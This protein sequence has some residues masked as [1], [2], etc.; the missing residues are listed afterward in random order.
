MRVSHDAVTT[1][2]S[3]H[4]FFDVQGMSTMRSCEQSEE[5][6]DLNIFRP[7]KLELFDV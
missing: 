1:C 4:F 3:G 6:I 5:K 7:K 2:M